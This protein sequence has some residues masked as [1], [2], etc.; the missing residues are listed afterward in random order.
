VIFPSP[1]KQGAAALASTPDEAVEIIC[2]LAADTDARSGYKDRM[3]AFARRYFG[4]MDGGAVIR[5]AAH[6]ENPM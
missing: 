4:P 2:R 6:I 3:S 1:E 5:I